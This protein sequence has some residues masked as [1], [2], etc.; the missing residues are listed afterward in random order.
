MRGEQISRVGPHCLA[1]HQ[2]R[3]SGTDLA[4]AQGLLKREDLAG[5]RAQKPRDEIRPNGEW[6]EGNEPKRPPGQRIASS[7]GP[8][9][10]SSSS[11]DR[12]RP[13]TRPAAPGGAGS[14][15]RGPPAASSAPPPPPPAAPRPPGGRE[16]TGGRAPERR[17]Q[18]LAFPAVKFLPVVQSSLAAPVE[19]QRANGGQTRDTSYSR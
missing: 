3:L 5:D 4:R 10:P 19:D 12:Q 17:R 7:R 18:R 15:A 11:A 14:P 9:S 2:R 13:L 6:F 16:R 1:I 8:R